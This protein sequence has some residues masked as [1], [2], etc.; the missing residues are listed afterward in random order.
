MFLDGRR[1]IHPRDG[2]LHVQRRVSRRSLE[3]AFFA[4]CRN[5]HA[6]C[7]EVL[8]D[9]GANADCLRQDNFRSPLFSACEG[10]QVDC[11]RALAAT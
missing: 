1:G 7:V 8:L 5:G 2:A 4:S 3:K 6:P 10:R 9:A 11:V